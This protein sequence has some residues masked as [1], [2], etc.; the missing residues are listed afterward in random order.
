MI[1][2]THNKPA[3]TQCKKQVKW[4]MDKRIDVHWYPNPEHA[5]SHE[6]LEQSSQICERIL[7]LS[8][9][10]LLWLLRLLHRRRWLMLWLN[11]LLTKL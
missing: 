11:W 6:G 8:L 4:D 10:L 7:S 9:L 5:A 3:S 1:S 2:Y